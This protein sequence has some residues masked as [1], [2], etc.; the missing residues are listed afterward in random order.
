[1]N[2]HTILLIKKLLAEIQV[3]INKSKDILIITNIWIKGT[4][5]KNII[6]SQKWTII[7]C[8]YPRTRYLEK[9]NEILKS[10]LLIL[11][12]MMKYWM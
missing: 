12:H 5:G 4:Q 8:T 3:P 11:N 6:S 10:I 9:T 7:A 1:M 2:N